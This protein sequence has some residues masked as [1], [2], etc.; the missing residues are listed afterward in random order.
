MYR[1]GDKSDAGRGEKKEKAQMHKT[2]WTKKRTPNS[3]L[4]KK[5]KVYFKKK[6]NIYIYGGIILH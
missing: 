1:K 2:T 6:K 3:F 5:H 4:V